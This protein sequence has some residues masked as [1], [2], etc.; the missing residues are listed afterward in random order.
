MSDIALRFD[1]DII[2]LDGAMGTM[3]LQEG[4][5]PEVPGIFWNVLDPELVLSI[6]QRYLLAGAQALTSD[7]FTGSRPVLAAHGLD[8]RLVEL[9]REAVR[10]VKQ[11]RPEHVLA[12]VGPC[13]LLLPPLGNASFSE[14][15]AVYAE[16]IAALAAE[17]PDAILIETMIDIADARAALLAARSVTDLPVFVSLSFAANGRMLLSGTTPAAAAITLAAAGAAVIGLNCN[18]EPASMLPLLRELAANCN[19]PLLVQPN[20]GDPQV[21]PDGRVIYSSSPEDFAAA[22]QSYRQAGAQFIGSCCGSTPSDTAAI[23]AEVGG[24]AVLPGQRPI[25]ASEPILRLS[26]ARS[27]LTCMLDG[28]CRLIGERLNPTGQPELQRSL[29]AGQLDLAASLAIDQAAAGA[30][31]LDVNVGGPGLDSVELLPPLVAELSGLTNC[32]LVLD[33]LNSTALAAAL[34]GYP[35]RAVINSISASSAELWRLLPLA[36][37]Y[38]AAVIARCTTG[39]Q[40]PHSLEERLAAVEII[41]QSAAAYDLS[42]SDLLFDVL[43]LAEISDPTAAEQALLAIAALHERGLLT[44]AAISNI[45]FGQGQRSQRN[46]DFL[47]AAVAAGLSMAIINPNDPLVQIAWQQANQQRAE[48]ATLAE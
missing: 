18:L 43:V 5:D 27:S 8:S 20:A 29:A 41:R 40:V 2:V 6:K 44:V 33:C 30:D 23:Y 21:L 12:D 4:A 37:Q 10:L 34:A 22:A 38:G 45:S 15:L 31:L 16:Q 26:S 1:R 32:P 28:P 36:R 9:N 17:D 14:V 47:R 3:L 24:L 7:S 42:D 39:G 46:A 13:G 25:A 35:G 48:P 11:L 19:C